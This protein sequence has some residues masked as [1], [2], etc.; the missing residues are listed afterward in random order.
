MQSFITYFLRSKP[1]KSRLNL[2]FSLL[3]SINIRRRNHKTEICRLNETCSG[4]ISLA[5]KLSD[6]SHWLSFCKPE[7]IKIYVYW[8]HVNKTVSSLRGHFNTSIPK[9]GWKSLTNKWYSSGWH[10]VC[11]F[12]ASRNFLKTY[13]AFTNLLEIQIYLNGTRKN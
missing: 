10:H 11:D 1:Y 12:E 7:C 13:Y 5:E 9:Q 6:L 8:F 3:H 4:I 2:L